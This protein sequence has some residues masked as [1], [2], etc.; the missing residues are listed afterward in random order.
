VTESGFDPKRQ[1]VI[2]GIDLPLGQAAA[3]IGSAS[4]E[5]MGTS[6]A[7]ITVDAPVRAAVVIRNA[8]DPYWHATLDGSPVPLYPGDYIDQ[9][10]LV[11]PGHHTIQL[12]YND[13]TVRVGL[14]CSLLV[15]LGLLSAGALSLTA[16][17]RRRAAEQRPSLV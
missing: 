15:V 9:A 5:A 4:Y 16:E 11:P 17:R 1:A 2:E 10:L 3:P 12:R 8:Y 13:P 6:S 14:A 7:T